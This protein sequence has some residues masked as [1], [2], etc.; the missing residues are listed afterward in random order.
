MHR[1]P[2][3]NWVRIGSAA[4]VTIMRLSQKVLEGLAC[5]EGKKD[6]LFFDKKHRGLGVRV[7]AGGGKSFIV[8]YRFNGQKRRVPLGALSQTYTLKNAQDDAAIVIGHDRQGE[9]R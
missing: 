7:T 4:R 3:S 2:S 9:G 8:Q 6:A 5:P 1:A